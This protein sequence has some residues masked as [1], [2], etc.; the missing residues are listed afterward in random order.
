[1]VNPI[2]A[3]KMENVKNLTVVDHATLIWDC[4]KLYA[5]E[6][7]N[8]SLWLCKI[9]TPWKSENIFAKT[10]YHFKRKDKSFRLFVWIETMT[11]YE[12]VDFLKL[13]TLK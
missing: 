3:Y 6:I 7:S 12:G 13:N 8:Q 2:K 1:M 10:F 4:V 9:F 11:H 5:L